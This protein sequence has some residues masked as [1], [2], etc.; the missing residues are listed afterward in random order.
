MRY[1]RLLTELLLRFLLWLSRVAFVALGLAAVGPVL[2]LRSFLVEDG[3]SP[4]LP[5]LTRPIGLIGAIFLAGGILL[6]AT[7]WLVP[8]ARATAPDPAAAADPAAARSAASDWTWVLGPAMLGLACG[9]VLLSGKLIDFWSA[10][11]TFLDRSGLWQEVQRGGEFSG[12]ILLP[13]LGILFA[14]LLAAASAVFLG[15]VP[16]L[17]VLLLA[18]RSAFFHRGFL[19]TAICQ[20][21]LVAACLLVAGALSDFAQGVARDPE[22]AAGEEARQFLAAIRRAAGTLAA[23]GRDHAWLTAG[24]WLLLLGILSSRRGGNAPARRPG[25]ATTEPRDPDVCSC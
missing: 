10:A 5:T 8:R 13:A 11:L 19:M 21:T 1:L 12:L 2:T 14:P 23:I 4:A 24:Y 7:R 15:V 16:L 3:T 22:L 20:V 9:T 6:F 25:P 17:L 18:T